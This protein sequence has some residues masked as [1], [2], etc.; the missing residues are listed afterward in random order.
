MVEVKALGLLRVRTVVGGKNGHAP[1]KN[2]V[3]A[4]P[5]FVSVEF[6]ANHKT[7]TKLR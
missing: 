3:L 6:H 5:L 4:D 2:V 1:C 7:V